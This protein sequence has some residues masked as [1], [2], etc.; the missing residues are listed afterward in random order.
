MTNLDE[1]ALD[2]AR[3]LIRSGQDIERLPGIVGDSAKTK[4]VGEL[5]AAIGA[6]ASSAGIRY[7]ALHLGTKGHESATIT[8]N[9]VHAL[10][11]DLRTSGAE[12][13][14]EPTE[15]EYD[16]SMWIGAEARLHG[17][18]ISAMSNHR[19]LTPAEKR[20]RTI[21]RKRKEQP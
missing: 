17:L 14:A 16:G 6:I 3:D 15:Q 4:L 11:E 8:C 13:V 20:K 21:E 19:N 10:V 2:V 9:D 12:I 1:G 5:L 18:A 7:I